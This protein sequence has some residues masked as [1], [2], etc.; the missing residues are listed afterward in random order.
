MAAPGTAN[1]LRPLPKP[2]PATLPF[3]QAAKEHRL[4][5]PR[6]PDGR[7][8]FYPRVAD[9]ETLG[10]GFTWEEVS[11]RGT[12]FS[13]TVD[14]RGTHPAFASEVPYVIAIVELEEGPRMTTNIVGCGVDEVYVGM[15]V[16][17]AF[18]DVT[19]EITLVKFRPAGPAQAAS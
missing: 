6:M 9:P 14:R 8:F 18:E 11:G 2:T 16:E 12:V 1:P 13:F 19:P 7:Y 17:A 5:M 10:E 3:W 4:L 15:P